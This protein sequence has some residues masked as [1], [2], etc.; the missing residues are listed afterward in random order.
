MDRPIVG[1][2]SPDG[3][4]L[5]DGSQWV[6]AIS[7]D[8]RWRWN[9]VAWVAIPQSSSAGSRQAPYGSLR[10][11]AVWVTVLM[12]G[13]ILVAVVET[14]LF[15]FYFAYTL[16]FG[17]LQV[18]YT[19]GIAGF[20]IF[21][22]SAAV[23]VLWFWRSHK[24]LRA[25]GANGL[26][27]T[28]GWAIGWWLIPVACLWMPFRVAM[29]IWK[30]SDPRSDSTIHADSRLRLEPSL[31]L[32]MWWGAWLASAV[33]SNLMAFAVA[34]DSNRLDSLTLVSGVAT[35]SAAILTILVVW[36]ITRRQA[37]RWQLIRR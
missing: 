31:L 23:F 9:G 35:A 20:L 37:E 21:L 2:L 33:L 25:L 15:R 18:V 27:F 17:D 22:I 7:P 19:V 16:T 6:G 36:S 30:A 10:A 34:P 32:R 24:N 26:Q 12:G 1:A 29:E 28:P 13:S 14:L 3:N 11:L 5:W 4:F 8:G